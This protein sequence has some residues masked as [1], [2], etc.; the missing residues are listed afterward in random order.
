MKDRLS[1][2]LLNNVN[3]IT[4]EE[5]L[6][7]GVSLLFRLL[8][9]NSRVLASGGFVCDARLLLKAEI[10]TLVV[11]VVSAGRFIVGALTTPFF[12]GSVEIGY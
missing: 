7:R 4:R 8:D 2:Y 1:I 10:L 9:R 3:L 6:V 11:V 5:T 12:T